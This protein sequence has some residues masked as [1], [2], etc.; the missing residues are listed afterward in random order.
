MPIPNVPRALINV[1]AARL[2]HGSRYW[3][4][5][6]KA[7]MRFG[8]HLGRQQEILMQ[9]PA[10]ARRRIQRG[11]VEL[12]RSRNR[13]SRFDDHVL[14]PYRI[15]RQVKRALA[16]GAASRRPIIVGPW[17]SE[18]GYEALYW[19]PF[20]HW[21]LDRYR[22]DPQRVIA[23]SR[24]GTEAWY[25]GVAG[26]Y[27]DVFDCMP[28]DEFAAELRTRREQGDQ[29][30]L[31]ASALDRRLTGLIA[32]RIGI[33]DAVVWHPGLMY[34]LFRSFWYGDRSLQFFLRHAD[35]DRARTALAAAVHEPQRAPLPSLPSEYAAVKFY[36]GPSLPDTAD[37]REAVRR[38]VE[39]LAAR[40]PVVMLDTAWTL[41]DHDDY[42]FDGLRG[43]TTLRPALDPRT[44][45]GLQTRVIAGARLFVG[46]CGGLAWL[47]PLLGVDTV[48][49]Y[50]DDRFLTPHLYAARYAYRYSAAAAFSTLNI[51]A[52]R[53]LTVRESAGAEVRR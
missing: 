29:K 44:N 19:V 8:R 18:V 49:V 2:R 4:G 51:R 21:V 20:L 41:D 11:R 9:A 40:M 43:V 36:T 25:R 5:L 3:H 17:T 38:Q 28:P 30:Q 26:R 32:D 27:V 37:N 12:V 35:F 23:V 39:R 48:A 10:H 47:A 16:R 13:L 24:G 31:A 46:T 14:Q 34:Q 1:T 33:R 6:T 15:E 22:V 50:D 53:A 52:M 42:A 7:A 45:L